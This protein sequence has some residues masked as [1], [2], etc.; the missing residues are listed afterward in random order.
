[1]PSTHLQKITT[2]AKHLKKSHPNTKWTNLVKQA[3]KELKSGVKKAVSGTK[4][5]TTKKVTKKVHHK[6]K[7]PMAKGSGRTVVVAGHH[8]KRKRVGAVSGGKQSFVSI[9]LE[10]GA[11]IA[12]GVLGTVVQKHV[13]GKALIKA[14]ASTAIGAFAMKMVPRN[15]WYRGI[16]VGMATAGGVNVLHSTGVMHGVD[17]MCAGIFSNEG[18]GYVGETEFKEIPNHTAGNYHHHKGSGEGRRGL[19]SGD[20]VGA[21]SQDEIDKWVTEG[22]PPVGGDQNMW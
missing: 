18:D 22:V 5:K 20:Y 8:K 12:G 7:K 4:K 14:G 9:V 15:K 10:L 16:G 1:M 13:P 6:K 21:Y 2:R 3:A 17:D 11:N 19:D